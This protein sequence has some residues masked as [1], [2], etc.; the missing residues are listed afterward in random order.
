M[1]SGVT[2]LSVSAPFICLCAAIICRMPA[3]ELFGDM[4]AEIIFYTQE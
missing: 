2:F 1:T 4:N 3:E